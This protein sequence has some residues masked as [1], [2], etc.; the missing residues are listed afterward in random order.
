VTTAFHFVKKFAYALNVAGLQ[1]LCKVS[2]PRLKLTN[3][4]IGQPAQEV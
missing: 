2:L 3:E 4:S 1:A